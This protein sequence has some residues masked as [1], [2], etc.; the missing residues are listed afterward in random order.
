M[1]RYL[2]FFSFSSNFLFQTHISILFTYMLLTL[3]WCCQ[4][5]FCSLTIIFIKI[6]RLYTILQ[7]L[8]YFRISLN[9]CLL[10]ASQN[11]NYSKEKEKNVLLGIMCCK[12]HIFYTYML[13]CLYVFCMLLCFDLAICTF[14]YLCFFI[15]G[16]YVWKYE[17]MLYIIQNIIKKI[18]ELTK[19]L[20]KLI[21]IK[22]K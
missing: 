3:T 17:F 18:V 1:C 8:S 10:A 20:E 5:N 6:L 15:S 13:Y 11:N 9:F 19:S 2:L 7:P 14:S 21:R 12:W 22:E 4:R 16:K